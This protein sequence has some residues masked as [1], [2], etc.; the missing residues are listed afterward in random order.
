VL[1]RGSPFGRQPKLKVDDDAPGV[2]APLAD[3]GGGPT[4][5]RVC[6]ARVG[7]RRAVAGWAVVGSKRSGAENEVGGPSGTVRPV[8]F[9]APICVLKFKFEFKFEA[10]QI[11]SK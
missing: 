2:I 8:N 3:A 5:Q 11:K 1:P 6:A 9:P 10:T 7:G 4:C